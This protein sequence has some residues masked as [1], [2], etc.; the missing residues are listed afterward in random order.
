MKTLSYILF[1]ILIILLIGS[2]SMIRGSQQQNILIQATGKNASASQLDKS[3]EIISKRLKDFSDGDFKISVIQGKNQI[4]IDLRGEWD[5]KTTENLV[6]HKGVIELYETFTRD[7]L[8]HLMGGNDHLFTLIKRIEPYKTT[9]N[10]GCA[11][12]SAANKVTEYI[13]TLGLN[14]VCKFAWTQGI[15]RTEI[16]LFALKLIDG[17]SPVITGDEIESAG[18]DQ[19]KISIKIKDSAAGTWAEATRRNLNKVIALVLDD[20]V[21]SYPRVMD[22]IESGAVEMSGRFTQSEG[23]YIAALLNNEALPVDFEIAK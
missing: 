11:S 21:I 13:N 2:G 14:K 23:R 12:V 20:H 17:K 22:V 16:C 7:S 1:P 3:A 10:L 15:G 8:L 19:G 9:E 6:T 18:F 5:L 4:R